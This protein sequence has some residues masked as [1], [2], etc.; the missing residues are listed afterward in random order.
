MLVHKHIESEKDKLVE[1]SRKSGRQKWLSCTVSKIYD[2]NLASTAVTCR[3]DRENLACYGPT[4]VT[5]IYKSL[6]RVPSQVSRFGL[7]VRR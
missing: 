3:E 5:G 1:S 6:V 2:V 4:E 7:A